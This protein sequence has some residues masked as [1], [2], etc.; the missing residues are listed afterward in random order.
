[1]T[2]EAKLTDRLDQPSSLAPCIDHR[3]INEIVTISER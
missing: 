1:M 2:A 3:D